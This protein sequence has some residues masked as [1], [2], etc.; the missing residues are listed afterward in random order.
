MI[1]KK[2]K[3]TKILSPALHAGSNQSP[4]ATAPKRVEREAI[5]ETKMIPNRKP[6]SA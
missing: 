6:Q 3:P 4:V 5:K 1:K 2:K